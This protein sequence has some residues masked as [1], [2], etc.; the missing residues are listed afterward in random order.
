MNENYHLKNC[1]MTFFFNVSI[2]FY[3][4]EKKNTNSKMWYP[5]NYRG[6]GEA[7]HTWGGKSLASAALCRK[8]RYSYEWEKIQVWEERMAS[9]SCCKFLM[10]ICVCK[11][12]CCWPLLKNVKPIGERDLHVTA[13]VAAGGVCNGCKEC[14]SVFLC[15]GPRNGCSPCM[16]LSTGRLWGKRV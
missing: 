2:V 15:T 3:A 16:L 11:T 12:R 8:G 5:L 7:Y 4:A 9:Q 6:V 14:F 1:T 13:R 10:Y